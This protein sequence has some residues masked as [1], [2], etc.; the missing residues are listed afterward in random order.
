MIKTHTNRSTTSS[1]DNMTTR[2]PMSNACAPTQTSATTKLCTSCL[3]HGDDDDNDDDAHNE[4]T[5]MLASSPTTPSPH[6]VRPQRPPRRQSTTQ[7]QNERDDTTTSL[8]R[9]SFLQVP[10]NL[11]TTLLWCRSSC[12]AKTR[13]TTPQRST[14]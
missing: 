2:T 13:S 4:M 8:R 10:H 11:T 1:A 7:D 6:V 3:S 12:D 9:S 14:T 5:T